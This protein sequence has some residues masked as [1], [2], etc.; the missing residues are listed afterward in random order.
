M[1]YE[2]IFSAVLTGPPC[3]YGFTPRWVNLATGANSNLGQSTESQN[4]TVPVTYEWNLNTQYEFLRNWV[5]E[6]GYVGS[7]G[8]HQEQT[9]ISSAQPYNW[10]P[11]AT[12]ASPALSGATTNTVANVPLRVQYLGISPTATQYQT[13]SAYKYNALQAV[14]RKQLS[15][16][17]QFQA[18]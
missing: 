16:G 12:P 10:A 15:H 11:L 1:A 17:L 2:A 4:F 7:H 14:V 3:T 9:A 18:A 8:I 13:N 5:L 6:L